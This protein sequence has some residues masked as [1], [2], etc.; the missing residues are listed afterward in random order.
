MVKD[1]NLD[2][3]H[4]K[5]F[6]HFHPH[7]DAMADGSATLRGI[8]DDRM[9]QFNEYHETKWLKVPT[10]SQLAERW[11]KDSNECTYT[12]KDE[13]SNS[14]EIVRS[15]IV[16]YF[17]V[18]AYEEHKDNTRK[19]TNNFTRRKLEERTNKR[20]GNIEGPYKQRKNEIGGTLLAKTIIIEKKTSTTKKLSHSIV[21]GMNR[22]MCLIWNG[23]CRNSIF[24]QQDGDTYN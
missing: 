1:T 5:S 17:N 22:E 21:Q 2:N 12:G 13:K 3:H 16:L 9:K 10:N 18:E 24:Q 20:T 15:R 23:N 19:V 6:H 4:Q 8:Y 7:L 11:V 14:L